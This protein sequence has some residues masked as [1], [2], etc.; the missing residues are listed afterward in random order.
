MHALGVDESS[1]TL[2]SEVLLVSVEGEIW[3]CRDGSDIVI[4]LIISGMLCY[5][6]KCLLNLPSNHNIQGIFVA[7][8]VGAVE[9][10]VVFYFHNENKNNEAHRPHTNKTQS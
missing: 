4:S 5:N 10:E 3:M 9:L 7:V 2:L 8:E 6:M 1:D